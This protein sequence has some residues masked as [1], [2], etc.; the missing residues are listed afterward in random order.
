M[1]TCMWGSC[2]ARFSS[3]GELVGHVNLAHLRIPTD[4][5]VSTDRTN[6]SQ[7]QLP[8]QQ[9]DATRL[10]CLWGNCNE[11]LEPH[12]LAGTSSASLEDI[13][14]SNLASHLFQDHLGLQRF[15]AG[16]QSN[17]LDVDRMLAEMMTPPSQL[18]GRERQ[19][20]YSQICGVARN[21]DSVLKAS[22]DDTGLQQIMQEV[23]AFTT[24]S[25]R[26]TTTVISSPATSS[27]EVTPVEGHV[28]QWEGCG[29]MFE[30]C[31]DLMSHM[32]NVHVGSGKPQYDCMWEGCRRNGD[33]GFSSKQKICRHLQ[34]GRQSKFSDEWFY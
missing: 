11:F 16:I 29:K 31:D 22:D 15:N 30:T 6:P 33:K 25:P 17:N 8:T 26:T 4:T 7:A 28:C 3:L 20:Q 12:S 19:A 5:D 18:Q 21:S 23:N 10:P 13:M 1:L 34:V 24:P 14:L 32:S 9:D 2:Q 27:S